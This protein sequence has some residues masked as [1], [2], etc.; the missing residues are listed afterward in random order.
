MGKITFDLLK[1]D[2]YLNKQLR[3]ATIW[4]YDKVTQT[5]VRFMDKGLS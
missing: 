4:S 5:F 3:T 1:E 2:Y